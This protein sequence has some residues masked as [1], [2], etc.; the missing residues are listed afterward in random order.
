MVLT[1]Q[2]SEGVAESRWLRFRSPNVCMLVHFR[3]VLNYRAIYRYARGVDFPDRHI[4]A[5][6]RMRVTLPQVSVRSF[7][8][9][10]SGCRAR[11]DLR[12][13]WR[14][15]NVRLLARGYDC[16]WNPSISVSVPWGVSLS[17]WP[18]CSKSRIHSLS[19][20]LG[21]AST[22]TIN[23]SQDVIKVG[24][25]QRRTYTS[26]HTDIV[27]R[28]LG[29]GVTVNLTVGTVSDELSKKVAVCPNW[30]GDLRLMQPA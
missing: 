11:S 14:K 22:F 25:E 23:R 29:L 16:G 19:Q 4:Y 18:S 3:G 15:I 13:A 5:V 10:S 1:D 2:K 26:K 28:C 20:S 17:A 30:R 8:P 9:T 24:G 27:W 7:R 21:R 6:D 12:I